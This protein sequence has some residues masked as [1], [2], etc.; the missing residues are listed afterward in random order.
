[1]DWN[2]IYEYRQGSLYAKYSLN[3]KYPVG[4][5]VGYLDKRGYIRTKFNGKMTFAHRIIWE[6]ISY[7]FDAGCIWFRVFGKGILIIDRSIH[8]PLFN[9]RTGRKK[10]FRIGKYGIQLIR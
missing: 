7:D 9:V 1:M 4:R 5:L 6:M 10:E 2:S 8:P 3:G